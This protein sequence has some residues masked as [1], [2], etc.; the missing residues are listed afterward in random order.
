[1]S[2]FDPKR[3]LAGNARPT[4]RRERALLIYRNADVEILISK[5]EGEKLL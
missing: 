1:M 5:Q 3:T 4:A 2:A